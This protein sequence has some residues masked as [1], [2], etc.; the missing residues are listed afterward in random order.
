MSGDAIDALAR[1]IAA[2]VALRRRLLARVP[3]PVPRGG[4][5]TLD[6]AWQYRRHGSGVAFEHAAT[7]ALVD[8]PDL[9][10]DPDEVDLH[11]LRAYFG[12]IGRR[13][14]KIV[15]RVVGRRGPLEALLV[16]ALARLAEAGHARWDGQAY[17]A[18]ASPPIEHG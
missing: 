2:F 5:V 11:V 6:D 16:E 7:R 13:G 9:E 1:E 17:R 14:A 3:R 18:R 15:E 4:E 10:L 12:S 8:M